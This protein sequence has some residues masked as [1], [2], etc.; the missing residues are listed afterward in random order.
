ML[1][2]GHPKIYTGIGYSRR[3]CKIIGDG[4]QFVNKKIGGDRLTTRMN[5]GFKNNWRV[6]SFY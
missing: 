3:Q 6:E 2:I 5:I 4:A 1:A